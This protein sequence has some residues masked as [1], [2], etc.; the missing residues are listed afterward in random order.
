M[1]SIADNR[2]VGVYSSSLEIKSIALGSALRNTWML[3][4]M[5]N[6]RGTANYTDL[7]EG[8]RLDLRELVLHVVGVHRANLVS[9]GCAEN[10]DDLDELVNA[11]LTGKERLPKHELSHDTA[12]RPY[13]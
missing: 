10:L 12:G 5:A 2:W 11:R 1:A 3:V 7:V 13:I 8:V 4:S 9:C 6:S